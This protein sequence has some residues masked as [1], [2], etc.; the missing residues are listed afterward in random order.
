M[1]HADVRI[2]VLNVPDDMLDD[3]IEAFLAAHDFSLNNISWMAAPID[4]VPV[5]FHDFNESRNIHNM[6]C[7][8][9]NDKLND[10]SICQEVEEIKN[11]EINELTAAVRNCGQKSE[12]GFVYYFNNDTCPVVAAYDGDEPCDIVILS[13]SVDKD[14]YLT[15]IGDV[16]GNRGNQHEIY[17][18][19]I[20]AGHLDYVIDAIN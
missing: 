14:G 20:F 10:F 17:N 4:Y 18:D 11:R 19:D 7:T 15:I 13:V 3:N 1:N 8:T 6:V 12:N 9:R 5:K 2:E 16:K